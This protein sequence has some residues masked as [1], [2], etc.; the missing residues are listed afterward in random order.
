MTAPPAMG[1]VSNSKPFGFE[2]TFFHGDEHRRV[3]DDFH[4]T[5]F[6]LGLGP[7]EIAH[8]RHTGHT[9]NHFG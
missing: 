5:Q 9:D 4:V 3:V 8:Q 1:T 6:A 2:E 7:G